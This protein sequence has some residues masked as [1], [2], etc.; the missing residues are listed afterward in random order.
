MNKLEVIAWSVDDAKRIEEGGADRIEL[1][2]DLERGGLTPPL[3]LV[4]EVVEAVNIPVRVM[5]RDDDHSFIYTH[6]EMESH[7][8]Y[9]KELTNLPKQPEGIV[10]GS[11]TVDKE[12]NY[13]QLDD[14]IN[15]KGD[16]KLTFH[17]AFDEL[18]K[19][20]AKPSVM[21]LSKFDVDTILTS[22]LSPT[23][24]EGADLISE[25]IGLTKINILPGKSIELDN[26]KEVLSRTGA[27][28]LHVGYA[29]RDENGNIDIN[30]VKELKEGMNND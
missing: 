3:E 4:K 18:Y 10:F 16:M 5:V 25:L 26:F 23:A 15:A 21:T 1:V 11:L 24:L 12:I 17:R 8:N 7:I 20:H 14:I 30:K 6:E 13:R 28:Y 2:V 22:G 9:V 29:V 19:P 27:N